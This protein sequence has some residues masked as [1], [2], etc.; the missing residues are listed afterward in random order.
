[1]KAFDLQSLLLEADRKY[2]E[3]KA[4]KR[5]RY[6][7]ARDLGFSVGEAMLLAGRSELFISKLAQEL[8]KNKH[9]AKE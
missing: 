1:M 3:L 4:R 7:L 8:P 6:R 2:Q 5:R 9:G